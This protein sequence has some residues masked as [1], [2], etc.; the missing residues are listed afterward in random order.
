MLNGN[1]QDNFP[2]IKDKFL[3]NVINRGDDFYLVT[4]KDYDRDVDIL[5]SSDK[6][7]NASFKRPIEPNSINVY[8]SIITGGDQNDAKTGLMK[9]IMKIGEFIYIDTVDI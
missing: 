8:D 5:H 2:W 4:S 6:L 9:T 1:G 3:R 7:F